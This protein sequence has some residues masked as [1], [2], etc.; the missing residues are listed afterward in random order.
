MSTLNELHRAIGGRLRGGDAAGPNGSSPLGPVQND[1]RRIEPGDVFWALQGPNYRGEAFV[2]EAFRRGASGAVVGDERPMPEEHWTL[3]VSD[4]Q[5]ALETWAQWRRRRSAAAVVAV[6][7]SAGKTTARQMIHAVLGSRLRGTA[8]P[9]NFNNCVGVPLSMTAIEPEHDYAVLEL[10]ASAPGEIAEL[11]EVAWPQIGVITCIGDAHLG[12]FG[13]RRAIAR[14][15]AELL[16]ALPTD[17]A[18]VLADDPLLREVVGRSDAPIIWVGV[19]PRC[20]LR[21]TE[22]ESEQGRLTFTVDGCE[23]CVPVWGRH[24]LNA[25]LCALA[26]GRMFGIRLDEMADA[27]RAFRP[28]PMRCEVRQV[29]G[30]TIIDD[31]YNS[32]PTAMRAALELLRDIDAPGRRIVVC[33]DMAELG[34]QSDSLHDELG[35]RIVDLG[36]AEWLVA[37]GEFSDQVIRGALAVGM[38]QDRA[39]SYPSVDQSASYVCKTIAPGDVVLIKGSRKMCMERL[40]EAIVGEKKQEVFI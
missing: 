33:G 24:H 7:G 26:V 31:T 5:Q 38:P 3:Q 36:R 18:A 29:G 25:T 20:D 6:T 2:D 10:G 19:D 16:A 40:V 14:A 9:A 21:A 17:G 13:S 22:I 34:E 11:A 27:L 15:K 8:S 30:A 35:R 12:G 23:F 39:V 37:C 4:A 32:N 28:M 1:S